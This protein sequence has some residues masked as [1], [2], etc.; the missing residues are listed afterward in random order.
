MI[1][2]ISEEKIPNF[3]RLA[4]LIHMLGRE[5]QGYYELG[6]IL[7]LAE[8]RKIMFY[9]LLEKNEI[10]NESIFNDLRHLEHLEWIKIEIKNIFEPV[11]V[12]RPNGEKYWKEFLQKIMNENLSKESIK[13]FREFIYDIRRKTEEEL[14]IEYIE[15]IKK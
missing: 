5:L 11:I 10:I 13:Q 4:Y 8:K 3:I 12:I 6:L 9:N 1:Q 7:N 15:T 2:T 14:E